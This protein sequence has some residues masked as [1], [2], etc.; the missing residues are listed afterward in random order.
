MWEGWEENAEGDNYRSYGL[1]VQANVVVSLMTTL[2]KINL[3]PLIWEV[4]IVAFSPS[5]GEYTL[6]ED[7]FS[8]LAEAEKKT[9]DKAQEITR[10]YH[11]PVSA[12]SVGKAVPPPS[13]HNSKLPTPL[14]WKNWY[15]GTSTGRIKRYS[16]RVETKDKPVGVEAALYLPNTDVL[17]PSWIVIITTRTSAEGTSDIIFKGAYPELIEAEDKAWEEAQKA[18]NALIQKAT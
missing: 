12:R 7:V 11:Q 15:Q 13:K 6:Y 9:W 5:A 10:S 18:V 3:E 16:L 4:E 2:T 8:N 17:I 14:K 1:L